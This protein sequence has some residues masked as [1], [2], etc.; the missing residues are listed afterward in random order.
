MH[1]NRSLPLS[2]RRIYP[3]HMSL[4]CR[5]RSYSHLT[6]LHQLN[7]VIEEDV[8]V[9]FTESFCVVGDLRGESRRI[10]RKQDKVK[11][12]KTFSQMKDENRAK[13]L[14]GERK[15]KE[16]LRSNTSED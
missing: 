10:I 13:K 7:E 5:N 4:L 12:F 14:N 3:H 2:E 16:G 8:S 15:E 1:H 6:A 9:P 11:L